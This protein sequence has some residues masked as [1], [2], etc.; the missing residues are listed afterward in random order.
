MPLFQS[1]VVFKYLKAQNQDAIN[2]KVERLTG[3]F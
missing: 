3:L 1:T 2:L